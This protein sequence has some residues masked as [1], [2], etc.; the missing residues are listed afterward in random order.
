[1]GQIKFPAA[2]AA[3]HRLKLALVKVREVSLVR[4]LRALFP[5]NQR[6]H[7]EAVNFV[8]GQIRPNKFCDGRKQVNRHQHRV[9]GFAGGNFPGPAHDARHAGAAF[10]TSALAF[11]QWRGGARVVAVAEPRAVVAGEDDQGIIFE[12]V[13][14]E[15]LE[16]FADAPVN[17][18]DD[19]AVESLL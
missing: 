13:L 15:C 6:P 8:F 1:M 19:I 17:F 14:L 11:A 5:S 2:V 4:I 7:I 9:A 3:R 16:D 10:P 12:L 18:H